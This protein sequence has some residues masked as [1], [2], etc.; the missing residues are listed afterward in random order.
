MDVN[1]Q[2]N[3][4]R[5]RKAKGYSIGQLADLVGTHKGNISKY[6]DSKVT[7][8]VV[9]AVKFAIVLDCT[10]DQLFTYKSE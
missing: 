10:L 6:E 9:T 4:R 3:L 8:N 7:M 2:C 5:L 1:I